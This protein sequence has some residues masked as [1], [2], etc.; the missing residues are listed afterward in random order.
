MYLRLSYDVYVNNG[1][2]MKVI[3]IVLLCVFTVRFFH[4]KYALV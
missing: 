1:N 2:G 4:N 3:L